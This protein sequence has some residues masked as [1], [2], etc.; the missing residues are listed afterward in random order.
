MGVDVGVGE[1]KLRHDLF[2][3]FLQGHVERPRGRL[4][5]GKRSRILTNWFDGGDY[6]R[7]ERSGG[8]EA[9]RRRRGGGMGVGEEKLGVV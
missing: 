8:E 5:G 2:G 3:F 6:G 7:E 9:V 4:Y 1:I